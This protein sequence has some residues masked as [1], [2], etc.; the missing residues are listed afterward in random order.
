MLIG[1]Y[2]HYLHHTA[3]FA[4]RRLACIRKLASHRIIR[5]SLISI[6][7]HISIM[8]LWTNLCF[9]YT[10]GKG[11]IKRYSGCRIPVVRVHGVD[12]DRVQFP[13]A[14]QK[15]FRKNFFIRDLKRLY[16]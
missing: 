14:R 5:Y 4:I 11:K 16:Y 12:V 6:Y 7:S 3:S 9:Q 1:I 10:V 8:L 13:A 15:F 2:L